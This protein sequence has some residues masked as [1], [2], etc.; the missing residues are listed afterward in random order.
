M[1]FGNLSAIDNLDRL[2]S[3]F[4]TQREDGATFPSSF[5]EVS[6]GKTFLAK[7]KEAQPDS[8]EIRA[9]IEYAESL[10]D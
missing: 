4:S 7:A 6:I 8:L 2:F 5:R 9:R 10:L 1:N 3:A